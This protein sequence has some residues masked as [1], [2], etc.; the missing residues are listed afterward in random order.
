MSV[1][2]GP[3]VTDSGLVLN[4]DAGNIKSYPGTGTIW[5]DKSGS[6]FNTTLVNGPTF[7]N[8]SFSFDGTDDQANVST[9]T[10]SY[11]QGNPAFT[12]EGWFQRTDTFVQRST[13][14]FGGDV[15]S[16]GFT[17]WC[18]N[19]TNEISIDLW[20][21]STYSTGQQYSTTTWR[22]CV[23][24]YNGTSF[25]TSNVI[26]YVDGVAYTGGNLLVLRGSSGTPNINNNGIVI[27]KSSIAENAWGKPRVAIFN[28]YNRVLTAQEVLQNYN[29]T[30]SR[31]N[32]T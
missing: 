6:K 13:W 16:Q 27:G 12:V 25:T 31:F 11:L 18:Y 3:N 24:T 30:K 2:G 5:Y 29:A 20:G 7:S 15:I 22:H 21:V 26:I 9:T 1:F 19:N 17:S 4:L 23:W 28:M 14:G 8:G 10:P 32:L